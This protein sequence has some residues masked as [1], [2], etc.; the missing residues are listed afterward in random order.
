MSGRASNWNNAKFVVGSTTY[1][2]KGTT[3]AALKRSVQMLE[4]SADGDV[5]DTTADVV[6]IKQSFTLTTNIP[7]LLETIPAGAKGA[8]SIERWD[9]A[10]K[11]AV[12]GGGKLY[13]FAQCVFKPM[14]QTGSQRQAG[15]GSCEFVAFSTDGQTNPLSVTAL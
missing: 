1:N 9:S 13:T 8:F 3:Q 4:E 11:G 12:A 5:F 6:G 7:D 2:V 14:D 15:T 10:G